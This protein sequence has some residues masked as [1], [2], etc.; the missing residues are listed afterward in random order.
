MEFVY[1]SFNL[2]SFVSN[3]DS[4]DSYEK[5]YKSIYAPLIKFLFSHPNFKF[6]ISCSGAEISFLKKR[7]NELFT[8]CK[9]M[10]ER[11]QMELLGGG[12]YNPVL[13]LLYPV[14]RNGQIDMLSSEIR[15]TFGKRPR[16]AAIFGDIWDASL[17]NTFN[18]CGIEYV[19]L[20]SEIIPSNKRK[21]LPLIVSDFGKSIDIYPTYENLV[22]NKKTE[23]VDFVQEILK[24]AEKMDRKDSYF[25]FSPNRIISISLTHAQIEELINCKWFEKLNSYL[26]A[27]DTKLKLINPTEYR[28]E[29]ETK[30]SCHLSTGISSKISE[31]MDYGNTIYDYLETK[32]NSKALYNRILYVQMMVNQYK[33]DKMRKKDARDKLWEAQNGQAI[34]CCNEQ[35]DSNY[36]NRQEAYRA[37][38]EAEKILRDDSFKPSITCFDYD[39]DGL[40]EYVCRMENYFAMVSLFSGSIN[41]LDVLKNTGNYADNLKRRSEYDGCSDDYTKG[42][43]V[44][45]IFNEVQFDS[46]VNGLPAGDGVFSRVKYSELKFSRHH[47]EIQLCAN[48]LFGASKQPVYLRKKYIINPTGMNVQYIIKNLSDKPLKAK[49]AVES[50]FANLDF[51][52][53]DIKYFNVEVADSQFV[54]VVDAKKSTLDLYKK[55]LLKNVDVVRLTDN[56]RGVSFSFEPNENCGYHFQPVIINRPK[57]ESSK[58]TPVHMSF[59]STLYWD[60]NIEPGKD[61][62]KNLNF[63]I[64][65]IKK[66]KKK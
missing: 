8:V 63:T 25:Q 52:A 7:H 20:D 9:T 43:F 14:D 66:D 29:N 2:K 22:P 27:N 59:T 10:I 1:V 33:G 30:V 16:G 28:K 31:L 42:I 17:V 11:N 23:I 3:D 54:R 12:F 39:Y 49:F 41:E 5:D 40:N 37:L 64:S 56:E 48:A 35:V 15:Q 57:K 6:N 36:H 26:E 47:N 60:I 18:T 21:F 45:H 51:D 13:P 58:L 34:V 55:D 53:N 38:M 32:P 24:M 65:Y 4:I 46:Y 61:T 50:N 62:E 44:D 19:Y